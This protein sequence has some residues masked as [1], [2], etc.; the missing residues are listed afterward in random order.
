MNDNACP[1]SHASGNTSSHLLPSVRPSV[2]AQH[3][4]PSAVPCSGLTSGVP[5]VS[6]ALKLCSTVTHARG[7]RTCPSSCL[8]VSR[9]PRIPGLG[10]AWEPSLMPAPTAPHLLLHSISSD[11]AIFLH[12]WWPASQDVCMGNPCR[13]RKNCCKVSEWAPASG[14]GVFH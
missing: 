6:Q 2:P 1:T 4:Q 14:C 3:T 5:L 13:G 11:E 8:P 10:S 7:S 12:G 9:V